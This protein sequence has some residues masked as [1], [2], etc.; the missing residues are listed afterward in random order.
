[1]G[2]STKTLLDKLFLQIFAVFILII[3]WIF[4]KG[5]VSWKHQGD[6]VVVFERGGLVFVLNFHH[7]SS[8]PDYK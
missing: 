1:M 8:F 5:F 2:G 6:K 7:S 3:I 4:V